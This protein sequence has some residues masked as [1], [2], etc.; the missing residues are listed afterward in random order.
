MEYHQKEYDKYI[1]EQSIK[2]LI[3]KLGLCID[4]RTRIEI[5]EELRELE[6]A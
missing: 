6:A 5:L 4:E 3:F 1:N 2:V